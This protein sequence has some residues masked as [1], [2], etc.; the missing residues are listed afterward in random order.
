MSKSEDWLRVFAGALRFIVT[1]HAATLKWSK[2]YPG[3]VLMPGGV[4]VTEMEMFPDEHGTP[5]VVSA[6]FESYLREIGEAS[7][8]VERALAYARV[9]ARH[10]YGI[11][12]LKPALPEELPPGAVPGDRV[13]SSRN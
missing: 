10:F 12:A 7:M 1:P 13:W 3:M 6:R 2:P 9:C 11:D 8:C 5:S 4:L